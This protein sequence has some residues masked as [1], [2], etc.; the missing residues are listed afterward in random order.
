MPLKPG[1]RLWSTTT[2]T[3]VVV[4]RPP[5]RE[6][7]LTCGGAPL[8]EAEQPA[9]GEA[10]GEGGAQLGKRYTDPDSGIELLCTRAGAGPLAADGRPVEQVAARPLPASD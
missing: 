1:T 6:I 7:E 10:P 4:V 3:S 9:R 8:A 2:S 5:T